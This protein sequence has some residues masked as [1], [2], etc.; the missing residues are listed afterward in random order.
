MRIP[1]KTIACTAAAIAVTAGALYGLHV[2]EKSLDQD[3]EAG[4][5]RFSGNI[6]DAPPLVVLSTTA[7]GSFRGIIADWLWYRSENLKQQGSYFEMVQLA[8]WIIDLQPNFSG[9]AVYLA[10]NLAYNVSVTTSDP[11]ERWRWVN[12]GIQLLRDKAIVYN[13][14]DD[15][16]Y[17]ELAWIYQHKMGH[18]LDDANV[19]YKNRLA[20]ENTA[21]LGTSP[22]IA[23]LAEGTSTKDEFLKKYPADSPIWSC[24]YADFD[25]LMAAFS[26]VEPAALPPTV[27]ANDAKLRAE[28]DNDLRSLLTRSRL[29]LDPVRMQ[30]L[31]AKYGDLDW[32][33]TESMALYWSSIGLEKKR[34]GKEDKNLRRMISSSLLESFRSGRVLM[35]DIEGAEI[36][37]V[38]N[39]ELADAALKAVE[40]NFEYFEERKVAA[41]K[42]YR[43]TK[44]NFL[45]EAVMVMYNYGQYTKAQEYY[46]MLVKENGAPRN[47]KNMDDFVLNDFAERVDFAIVK[48]IQSI[49][50]GLLFRSINFLIYG[51]RD[52]AHANERM[53]KMI[54]DKYMRENSSE[55]KNRL[56]EFQRM[57]N[58]I[59]E[60][61]LKRLP[62][63]AAALL[64]REL[65]L[66]KPK[67]K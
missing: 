41:A 20:K 52:A 62:D 45:Q 27:A 42:T 5:L 54:Y 39:I 49:I 22:D 10:W 44:I 59:T 26:A 11:V 37:L 14:E 15:G 3:I 58:E 67:E 28:L 13:P 64:K 55:E 51:D 56:P 8:K 18:V 38:P 50:T 35:T 9:S 32:R 36:I 1:F 12:A 17:R 34:Y 60:Q 47:A 57:K 61:C 63:K 46:D 48:N 24:G 31:N 43:D 30:S 53:A 40:D 23:K 19:Y 2:L 6:Q 33:S 7:L 25:S 65:D 21:V 4:H 16:P 66:E 29:K